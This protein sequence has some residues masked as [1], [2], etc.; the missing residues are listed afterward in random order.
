MSAFDVIMSEPVPYK[1]VILNQITLFW[2]KKFAHL[3]KNHLISLT[4]WTSSPP[5][6]PRRTGRPFGR[7]EEGQAPAGGMHRA[8][9]HHRLRLEGLQGHRFRLRL[10]AA[11][12]PAGVRPP[13]TAAVHPVHK[14]EL[15]EHDTTN[16][17]TARAAGNPR[18]DIARSN[19]NIALAS[20]RKA[21]RGLKAAA[22]SLPTPSSSSAWSTAS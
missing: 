11:R 1:G 6:W 7:N 2:M 3:V 20:S 22:S 5:R 12:G 8:R 10:Q 19:R 17:S 15:G 13:R 4:T 14:A 18:R 16:I 9:L 21:A